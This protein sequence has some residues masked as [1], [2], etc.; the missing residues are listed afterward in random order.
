MNNFLAPQ[1][2]ADLGVLS[3]DPGI[4][5]DDAVKRGVGKYASREIGLS[6]DLVGADG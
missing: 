1:V 4:N 3:P 5:R 2:Q 6:E